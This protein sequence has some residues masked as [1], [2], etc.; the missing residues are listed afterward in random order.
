MGLLLDENPNTPT[1]LRRNMQI[2]SQLI[3]RGA[4]AGGGLGSTDGVMFVKTG[5]GLDLDGDFVAVALATDGG[6]V[7]ETDAGVEKLKVDLIALGRTVRTVTSSETLTATDDIV[8][9]DASSG[10]VT[11]T[12]PAAADRAWTYDVGKID[13]SSNLLTIDGD[14]AETINGETTI[15]IQFQDDTVT[16]APITGGWRII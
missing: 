6:I 3:N 5:D 12:L 11:I 8:L 9:V 1:R 4:Q 16:L 14:G 7:F 2:L 15:Q 13:A 10:A